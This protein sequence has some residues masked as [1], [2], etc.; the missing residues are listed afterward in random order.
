[1]KRL[2]FIS[3]VFVACCMAVFLLDSCADKKPV[4]EV[5]QDDT[6]SNDSVADDIVEELISRMP[7]TKVSDELF[8]DF[9]FNFAS[10][11][12][13]QKSRIDFPLPF[14]HDSK[15][16]SISSKEWK[17]EY[18]FMHNAIYTIIFDNSRQMSAPQDTTVNKVTVEHINLKEQSIKQYHFSRKKGEWRMNSIEV[19]GYEN[20]PNASFLSFYNQFTTDSLF[21]IRSIADPLEFSGPDPDDE[22]SQMEGM[23]MPEQWS[24]F[25]PPLPSGTIYNIV[26]GS[27]NTGS[28]QK[29][30]LMQGI[31]NGFL[32]ELVFQKKA[33]QWQLVRMQ[34]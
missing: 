10:S 34:I 13:V 7:V 30:L 26:Y 29:I 9:F 23:L 20:H 19:S 21:Q 28:N 4:Q 16:T 32:T 2:F 18:F 24:S 15:T 11:R 22:L 6:T 8:D 12:K 5:Q 3:S 14:V 1:M 31:A 33:G 25:A 27:Q 17:H